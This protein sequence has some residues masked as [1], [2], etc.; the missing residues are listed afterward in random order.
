[1]ALCVFCGKRIG[2]NR[3]A[4][5]DHARQAHGARGQWTRRPAGPSR[6]GDQMRATEAEPLPGF[7]NLVGG[8]Q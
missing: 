2:A 6:P 4:A 8:G 7:E 5:D 1:L 3:R